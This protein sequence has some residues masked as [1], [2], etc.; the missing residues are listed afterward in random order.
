MNGRAPELIR[1]LING[2]LATAVHFGILSFNLNIVDFASAGLANLIAS[3]FGIGRPF[4]AIA[5]SYSQKQ[6]KRL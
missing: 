5:I 6:G 3:L 4:W 2:V 1:Y